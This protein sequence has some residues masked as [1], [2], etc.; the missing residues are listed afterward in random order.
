[1]SAIS[2]RA[3]PFEKIGGRFE[4]IFR[5][6]MVR[7]NGTKRNSAYFSITDEE[8]P[9]IKERLMNVLGKDG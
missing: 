8:W 7:A 4:G 5:N 3:K 1:M 6:D 2:A 9:E